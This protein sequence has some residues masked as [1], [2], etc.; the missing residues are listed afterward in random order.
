MTP[1]LPV[2]EVKEGLC[3]VCPAGCGVK[4][5]ICDGVKTII[6]AHEELFH[7]AIFVQFNG[8]ITSY[9]IHYTKLYEFS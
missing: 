6:T 2:Y 1:P 3:G 4:I 7:F 8:V 9:S 5:H